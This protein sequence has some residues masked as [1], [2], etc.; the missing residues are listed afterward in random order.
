MTEFE[1]YQKMCDQL[2]LDL[3][4]L[5]DHTNVDSYYQSKNMD[6]QKGVTT[7]GYEY[8]WVALGGDSGSY[9]D[10]SA[11]NQ[12]AFLALREKMVNSCDAI[13]EKY[14]A[15]KDFDS[16]QKMMSGLGEEEFK[17]LPQSQDEA[18]ARYMS[19]IDLTQSENSEC[20][21]SIHHAKTNKTRTISIQDFGIGHSPQ[22]LENNLF[23]KVKESSK[24]RNT[25]VTGRFKF[26][27]KGVFNHMEGRK[28]QLIASK[29]CP[30]LHH[31]SSDP[32][33]SFWS[34]SPSQVIPH[35][36]LTTFGLPMQRQHEIVYL[37]FKVGDEWLVP[38]CSFE[39]LPVSYEERYTSIQKFSEPNYGTYIKFYN[40]DLHKGFG[41][42]SSYRKHKADGGGLLHQNNSLFQIVNYINFTN[43][44]FV[45]PIRVIEPERDESPTQNWT[46]SPRGDSETA[47]GLEKVLAD[48]VNEK[49]MEVVFDHTLKQ[50]KHEAYMKAYYTTDDEFARATNHNKH[51]PRSGVV[52]KIF[53]NFVYFNNK[54][55]CRQEIAMN[56]IAE[57]LLV[58]FDFNQFPMEDRL[59]AVQTN[60]EKLASDTIIVDFIEKGFE[61][62]K[63]DKNIVQLL[64]KNRLEG[65]K[66]DLEINKKKF[67]SNLI[68]KPNCRT[69]NELGTIPCNTKDN[70]NDTLSQI[71]LDDR[72]FVNFAHDEN[73][74]T[75]LVLTKLVGDNLSSFKIYF[76]HDA[77]EKFFNKHKMQTSVF[78]SKE[79]DDWKE[80]K[81][82]LYGSSWAD[83][84]AMM[85]IAQPNEFSN[86]TFF[87]KIVFS[88]QSNSWEFIIP[89]VS[90]HKDKQTHD[91]ETPTRKNKKK[92][93]VDDVKV[94]PILKR[95]DL[96]KFHVRIGNEE[97][98]SIEM[99][100][101]HC[102]GVTNDCGQMVLG[103]NMMHP[104]HKRITKK[105]NI[106]EAEQKVHDA[107]YLDF[108]KLQV[109][110]IFEHCQENNQQVD[111]Y[112]HN[113]S[114][115][116]IGAYLS[117]WTY[118]KYLK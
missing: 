90:L 82:E 31:L 89:C 105:K 14:H 9:A 16:Y 115:N 28:H 117:D 24:L 97:M 10:V 46:K 102:I 65:F 6:T 99:N 94:F 74:P 39:N 79:Q 40:F 75:N 59:D 55:F 64:D 37:K 30:D 96:N 49:K 41:Q 62:L 23:Y 116:K 26:G 88:C 67:L 51:T 93:F 95:D 44:N 13:L 100:D 118:E 58:Y 108:M 106:S 42:L 107:W 87:T 68:F 53:N 34:F 83:G 33:K 91:R 70:L 7:S 48:K 104:N 32:L 57:R 5:N 63:S 4:K 43:P 12:V 110:P 56:S 21:M 29:M 114:L 112:W 47:Y 113:V 45:T 36:E 15:K 54:Y 101:S 3:E 27:A 109:S 71:T 1:K 69:S 52:I 85:T 73:D 76:N 8:E 19:D 103:V 20:C 66:A 25:Y 60:K 77:K 92:S 11:G 80:E 72:A 86:T 17:L 22:S 61:Q 84:A 2:F 78:F 111:L 81:S 18:I 38:I 50:N 35:R 98:D